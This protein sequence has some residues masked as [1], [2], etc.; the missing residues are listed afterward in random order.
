MKEQWAALEG[1]RMD[2]RRIEELKRE[3]HG[4]VAWIR[5]VTAEKQARLC[6]I[7]RE[8][9]GVA[10]GRLPGAVRTKNGR[11]RLN[12]KWLHAKTGE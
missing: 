9:S 6:Q 1:V 2:A 7:R 5:D 11:N 3:E 4:L 8:L 10:V 12:G